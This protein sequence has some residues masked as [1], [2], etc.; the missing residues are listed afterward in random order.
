MAIFAKNHRTPSSNFGVR[1]KRNIL[2]M[3][4]IIIEQLS[5]GRCGTAT[6]AYHQ[7]HTHCMWGYPTIHIERPWDALLRCNA[8]PRI[9]PSPRHR[10]DGTLGRDRQPQT[11]RGYN[12]NGEADGYT[13]SI[14]SMTLIHRSD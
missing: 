8:A 10:L 11:L 1:L 3:N 2:Y 9:R 12:R 14:Y 13:I 4:S 6:V 5:I 7:P